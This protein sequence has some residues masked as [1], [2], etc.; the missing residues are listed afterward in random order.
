MPNDIERLRTK[1]LVMLVGPTAVGKSTIMNVVFKQDARFARV[2]GF[3]TRQPRPNDEPGL[4][5]YL[6]MDTANAMIGAGELLQHAVN[7]ANGHMYGTS[8]EDYPGIYNMKDTL[9][10]AVSEFRTLPFE[11]HV[12]I[13]L[14][15]PANTW[16]AWLLSRYPE[17]GTER[18]NRLREAKASIEWS[19][20]QT[21]D[22][23]WLV[24]HSGDARAVAAELV[25][26]ATGTKATQLTPNEPIRMLQMIDDLLSYE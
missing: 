9:S 17:P 7:P 6:N 25:A 18:E 4:Y 2:S 13:S 19:L 16:Q 21:S 1:T 12:V 20:E 11:R 23:A 14:T 22:H 3:T 15:V 5:R 10:S 26:L 24:N 8:I